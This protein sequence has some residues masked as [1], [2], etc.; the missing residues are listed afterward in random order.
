L[1]IAKAIPRGFT[2]KRKEPRIGDYSSILK[3]SN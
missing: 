3:G 1:E 2:A